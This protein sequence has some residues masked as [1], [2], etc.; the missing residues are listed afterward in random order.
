M[1]PPT[2]DVGT[3]IVSVGG[4]VVGIVVGMV[5]GSGVGIVVGTV[6]I[7]VVGCV[8]GTVVCSDVTDVTGSTGVV[9]TPA[10]DSPAAATG[11][12]I[13]AHKVQTMST[14]SRPA[15]TRFTVSLPA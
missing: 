5:V 11:A 8:I 10:G 15:S 2:G 14:I 1:S 4:S 13:A 12:T 6:V 9:M 3:V 7:S